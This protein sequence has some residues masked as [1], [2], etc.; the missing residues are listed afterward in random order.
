MGN[1]PGDP[2]RETFFDMIKVTCCPTFRIKSFIFWICMVDILFYI[3][4]IAVGGL[5]KDHSNFLSPTSDAL[6]DF[7][8]KYPY[9]MRY[10]YQMYRWFM[11]VFL[12]ATFLHL[13][14][15]VFSSM[16]IGFSFED[17]FGLKRTIAVY[18][19]SGLGGILFSSLVSDEKSVGASCA[20]FGLLGGYLGYLALHWKQLDYPNSPRWQI[21]ISVGIVVL[22]S[23]LIGA[24][25]PT[26]DWYG[27]F[28]GL[29]VGFF[30]S[31]AVSRNTGTFRVTHAEM[32]LIY[33]S[34]GFCALFFVVGYIIFYTARHPQ[35]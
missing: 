28:G 7:G 1:G 27:H 31:I 18:F 21:L 24:S 16:V 35:P 3:V 20:I 12:H 22:L 5:S 14:M 23:L 30:I 26:I 4:L 10:E 13:L 6:F 15:N 19:I 34:T 17:R 32:R 25:N 9:Y 11:P 2:R 8:E 33:I 29:L